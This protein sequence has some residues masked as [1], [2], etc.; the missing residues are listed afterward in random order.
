MFLRF[1]NAQSES[2]NGNAEINF[3]MRALTVRQPW[4]N[5]LCEG[6]KT[7][8]VRSWPTEYRGELLITAARV[9]D[10]VF[11]NDTEDNIKRLLHAGCIIGVVELFDCRPMTTDDEEDALCTHK[12]GDWAWH[13]KP[14]RWCRPD[15]VTGQLKLFDVPDDKIVLLQESQVD[16]WIFDYPYPQGDKKWNSKCMLLG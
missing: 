5:L 15:K 6:V 2:G 16:E 8:E 9:P 11:W 12:R 3:K 7:V 14:K 10:N 13:V 4:A 1:T